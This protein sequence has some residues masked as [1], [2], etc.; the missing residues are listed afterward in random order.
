MIVPMKH[1]TLLCVATDRDRTLSAL[2][3]LGCAHLDLSTAAS[4]AFQSARESLSGAERALRI[5]SAAKAG[6]V[7]SPVA[8]DLS[9]SDADV[10]APAPKLDVLTKDLVAAVLGADAARQRLIDG[11]DKLRRLVSVYAPFGD[12][13]PALAIRLAEKGLVVTLV[14]APKAFAFK[15]AAGFADFLGAD[16]RFA[17]YAAVNAGKLPREC[18]AVDL[19]VEKVSVTAARLAK[20][21]ARIAEITAALAAAESRTS[22]I[23]GL[24]PGLKDQVAFTAAEDVLKT[25]GEVAWIQGWVPVDAVPALRARAVKESWGLVVR[26]PAATEIPPTLIRPPKLFRPVTAL[27][28]GL[29]IAPAY[30]ESDVSIPFFCYFSIF[31]A[32]LVGDAGYGAII[33]ALTLWAWHKAGPR[34]PKSWFILLTVFAV[35]TITWGF[36]TNT[37]FGA[38][39]SF[40]ANP[41]SRWFDTGVASN[42]F[43]GGD[44]SYHHIMLVCFTIGVSHLMIAR[45]WNAV[46]VFPDRTF[47]SQLGWAGILLFM[48]FV[49]CTI[50]G[51]FP[52]PLPQWTYYVFGASLIGVFGF[53][54][55]GNELKSRGIE[56]G[57]LPLNIMSALGDIISYVRLFA[58]GLA[59]VKVAQN[60]NDMATSF[61]WPIY[62]KIIPMV[63]ILLVGHALNF[64]MA[65]L[66]IL[67]HAVR[68]NTLEFSNHKGI[69]WAGYAFSPFRK[70]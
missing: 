33:L 69:S 37:W 64:A 67:V 20:A 42:G 56:L 18:E 62:L 16:S 39:V 30:N 6:K 60:F 3:E 29:G 44:A 14:R 55:K 11:A 66:S 45:V 47:L 53:T 13:D 31:F 26:D 50:V 68:L 36:L 41:V 2:R 22:N 24:Q 19:P 27:F 17:Y 43:G 65:G 4:P 52:G 48:Y 40:L 5:L 32:M 57:M 38:S 35:A 10:V 59:S 51:I 7:P 12:F 1:L 15:P 70:H 28:A 63:L 61:A 58:V 23:V 46:C 21:E 8:S 9:L 54:L 49:T 34:A 25:Q